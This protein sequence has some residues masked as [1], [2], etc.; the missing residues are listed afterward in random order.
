M[1]TV[2]EANREVG[3]VPPRVVTHLL[4]NLRAER[5]KRKEEMNAQTRR[6]LE[7]SR[8]VAEKKK[9]PVGS[10]PSARSSMGKLGGRSS[11][12]GRSSLASSGGGAD[13]EDMFGDFNATVFT[14]REGPLKKTR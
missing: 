11:T 9:R 6:A 8:K 10:R 7:R 1:V 13:D 2:I 3:F 4:E 5:E 14:N 12:A